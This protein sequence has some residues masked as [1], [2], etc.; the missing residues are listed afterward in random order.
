VHEKLAKTEKIKLDLRVFFLSLSKAQFFL[1]PIS[2]V[3]VLITYRLLLS[4]LTTIGGKTNTI[5][6][7]LHRHRTDSA[8]S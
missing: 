7:Q 3:K 1:Q 4:I 6:R 8:N 2:N 5:A